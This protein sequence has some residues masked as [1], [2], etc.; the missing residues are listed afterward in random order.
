L[1]EKIVAA[2]GVTHPSDA[3]E[4]TAT[5]LRAVAGNYAPMMTVV[6]VYLRRTARATTRRRTGATKHFAAPSPQ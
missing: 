3:I 1:L 2:L 4:T 6:C 5:L